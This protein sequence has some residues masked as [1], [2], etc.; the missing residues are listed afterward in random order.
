MSSNSANDGSY[1]LTV[2]FNV[3]SDPD[4]QYGQRAKP[5]SQA[6]ATLPEE[7][8]RQGVIT[9]KQSTNMLM[10]VNL[11]SPG[12]TYDS[13][14]LNNYANINVTDTLA[15]VDGIGKASILGVQ[16]YAMRVWL[17]PEA[18]ASLRTHNRRRAGS[19]AG[20]ERAGGRGADRRLTGSTRYAV[21]MEP[22]QHGRL[23]SAE[24]FGDI[25]ISRG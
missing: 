5:V 24:E 18:L 23:G 3:G 6:M 13:L 12:Q 11:F 15:R 14:F 10:V 2:S 16:D 20:T 25:I 19:G 17:N 21:S 7:V 4:I 1:T 8:E 22:A 9:T